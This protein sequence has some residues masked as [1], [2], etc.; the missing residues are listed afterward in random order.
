MYCLILITVTKNDLNRPPNLSQF[1]SKMV[2][3]LKNK[4]SNHDKAITNLESERK[5]ELNH[6]M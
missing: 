6:F 2:Q 5:L 1:K 3:S 4:Q